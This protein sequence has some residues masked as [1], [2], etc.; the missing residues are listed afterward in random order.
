MAESTWKDDIL[1]KITNVL[2][3]FLF[4]GSN[5][6]TIAAPHDIYYTG[7]ETYIT[8]APWAFL[9]WTLI[10]LLLLGTIVY[11][12]TVPGKKVIVDAISWRFPLLG[13]L[14]A[15]YVNLWSSHHYVIAFI[16]ALFVS[17]TVTHVYYVVK[18]HHAPSN[19][20]DEIFVHLPFSLWHGWTTVLVVI[21]AFEAFGV[22]ALSKPPGVWTKVF[23]FLALFFLEGTSAAYAFTSPEGDLPASIAIMWSLFAI[24]AQQKDPFVHWSALAFAILSALCV[25]KG[26]WGLYGKYR[27]G[28]ILLED[29]ERAPLVGGA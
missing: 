12:F 1:L 27:R 14:N 24:F 10:H 8:P 16:F 3:Y 25:V 28:S 23:V 11:Q 21:T 13:I 18:K 6:Y 17:S 4:L 9:I 5:I 26:T 22:N 29:E 15:I 19:T 2:V 7:K 20:G